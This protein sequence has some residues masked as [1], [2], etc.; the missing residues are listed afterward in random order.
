VQLTED[1]IASRGEKLAAL[2]QL[3]EELKSNRAEEMQ[4]WKKR[5]DDKQAEAHRLAIVITGG[6]EDR[7]VSTCTTFD[8]KRLTVTTTR[9]DTGEILNSRPMTEEERQRE[10][11]LNAKS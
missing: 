8:Y 6:W 11:P 3:L 5:I 9:T 2:F 1:E 4:Q 7:P 10:L